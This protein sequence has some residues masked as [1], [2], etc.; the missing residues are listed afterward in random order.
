M[1]SSDMDDVTQKELMMISK[2]ISPYDMD[3]IALQYLKVLVL[4]PLFLPVSTPVPGHE[5]DHPHPYHQL[6]IS[7]SPP[8]F[9]GQKYVLKTIF[10]GDMEWWVIMLL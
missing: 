9:S 10:T 2:T 8:P 4:P 3:I 6:S 5:N 7:L 1:A